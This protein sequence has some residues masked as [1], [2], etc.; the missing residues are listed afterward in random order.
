MNQRAEPAAPAA[1]IDP[2][3]VRNGQLRLLEESRQALERAAAAGEPE[4]QVTL[5]TLLLSGEGYAPE[6][7]RALRLLVEAAETGYTP[8]LVRLAEVKSRDPAALEEAAAL[9]TEAA[10]RGS[11]A[12]MVAIAR[13]LTDGLGAP[14]DLAAARSRLEE[15][16]RL[17]F[18]PGMHEYGVFV[19]E[20]RGGRADPVE[21]FGW[22]YAAFAHTPNETAHANLLKLADSLTPD[23]L[24]RARKRGLA[25][26]R[27]QARERR[28]G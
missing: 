5:A 9:W 26:A 17:W 1:T 28:H 15:A 24:R 7:D 23:E 22:I 25:L 20:G 4:A 27:L 10:R 6:P 18:T 8:A 14:R 3:T 12:A 13:A 16:A 2:R 11:P 19:A 21:G